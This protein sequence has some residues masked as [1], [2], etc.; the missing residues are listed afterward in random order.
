MGTADP[1]ALTPLSLS[2]P[3]P[4]HSSLFHPDPLVLEWTL[5]N[6]LL[7][8]LLD[9]VNGFPFLLQSTCCC[10]GGGGE[11]RTVQRGVFDGA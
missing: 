3:S 1:A 8:F 5:R 6:R 2:L 7:D 4:C 11:S 10:L 9:L